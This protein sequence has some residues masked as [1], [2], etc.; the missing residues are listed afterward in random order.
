MKL[1]L[2][3]GNAPNQKYLAG[4][5]FSYHFQPLEQTTKPKHRRVRS[6]F[7]QQERLRVGKRPAAGLR[8]GG[9]WRRAPGAQEANPLAPDDCVRRLHRRTRAS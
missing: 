6:F 9:V 8:E 5:S 2:S 3:S 4:A 1:K 7:D